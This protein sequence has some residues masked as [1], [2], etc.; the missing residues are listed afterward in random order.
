MHS[1][2]QILASK[3]APLTLVSPTAA[4]GHCLLL[5][6][7]SASL[8]ADVRARLCASFPDAVIAGCTTAGEI[9]GEQ[10]SDDQLVLTLLC[11]ASST[12]ALASVSIEQASA[13]ASAGREL[14]AALPARHDGQA[15]RHVLVF[16]DGLRVNGTPLVAALN[17]HLPDG[18][19]VTG[20]LAADGSRFAHTAVFDRDGAHPHRVLAVGLYGAALHIGY[21]SLGGWDSFGPD[22]R[23]TRSDGNVLYELD[24][25]SALNLYKSYLGPFAKELPASALLFPL[26]LHTGREQEGVVRTILGIDES[27]QAMTFAGDMPEGGYV[28]LMRAN[29]DRLI[30]G[31]TGAAQLAT[32]REHRVDFAL[33]ISCV[34]RRLVLKQR[35][36]EEVESVRNVLGSQARL[37]GFYSYGE[38]C[39]HGEAGDCSL[40]NQ[41]M[42]I[43][44]LSEV[45]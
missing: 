4:A 7:G 30:E 28:R 31:S 3:D 41:T 21:G 11:F 35:C 17:Q 44:T 5:A 42:T 32:L 23:I 13:S 22:R 12:V 26:N 33:L 34:G 1:Q 18:V 9:G 14:A 6:F 36:E 29:F 19:T 15:L 39:P 25:Q 37:T 20:G 43:T 8:F 10:I 27:T 24:G 16:S 40:H 38:L 2:Q 45:V